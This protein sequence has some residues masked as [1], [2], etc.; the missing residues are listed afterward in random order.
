MSL[1]RMCEL[2]QLAQLSFLLQNRREGIS[3]CPFN[4]LTCHYKI[5][6]IFMLTYWNTLSINLVWNLHSPAIQTGE[7]TRHWW[8]LFQSA[9]ESNHVNLRGI[10]KK[11]KQFMII[12]MRDE[13]FQDTAAIYGLEVKTS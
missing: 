2:A 8:S 12:E 1:C 11:N 3:P 9:I 6:T 13:M 4:S 5:N 7:L 10:P